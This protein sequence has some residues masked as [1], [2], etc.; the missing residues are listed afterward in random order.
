MSTIQKFVIVLVVAVCPSFVCAPSAIAQVQYG[1][2]LPA[3]QSY[4]EPYMYYHPFY[5][6]LR[7]TYYMPSNW[8]PYPY[9]NM[10]PNGY[11]YAYPYAYAYPQPTYYYV[12]RRSMRV[13]L[14]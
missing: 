6:P 12:P 7:S 1:T 3:V 4:N 13:W 9:A 5:Q 14:R 11:P 2:W 10:Y 8:Q